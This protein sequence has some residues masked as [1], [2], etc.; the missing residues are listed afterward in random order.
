[1][2]SALF[3]EVAPVLLVDLGA[4]SSRITVVDYG[5]VRLSHNLDRGA[6]DLTL[7]LSRS[8][9]IDFER[10]E[11]L[12]RE[13]GL[14]VRPEHKEIVS[15]IQPLL[16]YIFSDG[17]KVVS[18]YRRRENRA[19]RRVML[20]GGGANLKGLVDFAINKFGVEAKLANPFGRVEYP[21]FLEP[22]LKELSPGFS[23]ALGLSLRALQE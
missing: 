21:A 22:V 11:K 12:K 20:T 3:R 5:I 18:E 1:M 23:T 15:V 2:R 16:D 7:S 6:Q 19:I 9:G 8:L 10:A 4:Q 13:T 14:S 17:L